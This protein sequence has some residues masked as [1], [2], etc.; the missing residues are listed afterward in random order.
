VVFPLVTSA[1]GVKFGKTEEGTVWLDPGRTSPY[2]FYQFW[3]NTDDE[4]VIPYLKFFTLMDREEVA[5]LR[6]ANEE[7]P[8][9]RSAQR[10]LAEEVTGRVHGPTGLDRARR[11]TKVLFGG[12]LEG[13]TVEEIADIFADVPSRELP[14][15]A[16]EGEGMPVLELLAESGVATSKGDARRSIQGGGVYLNNVRIDDVDLAVKTDSALEGRFLVL[17]K[18]KKNYRL[19][20]LLA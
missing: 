18:G 8:H 10:A 16:L 13:L 12:G 19:V 20:E 7:K 15:Q 11:A 14:R 17:R 5:E 3:L 9:E 2:R 6:S 1:T 4:D